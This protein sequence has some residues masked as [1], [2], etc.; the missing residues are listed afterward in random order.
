MNVSG[1]AGIFPEEAGQVVVA[2]A[3]PS[4]NPSTLETGWQASLSSRTSLGY[5]QKKDPVPP[6]PH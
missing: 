2:V 4:F 6:C 5:T 1:L 3:A